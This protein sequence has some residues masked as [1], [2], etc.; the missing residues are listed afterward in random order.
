MFGRRTMD[1][2][3]PDPTPSRESPLHHRFSTPIVVVPY[4][5]CFTSRTPLLLAQADMP[6]L[7]SSPSPLPLCPLCYASLLLRSP[8]LIPYYSTPEFFFKARFAIAKNPA[9]FWDKVKIEKIMR[10]GIILHNMIVED[11]RDGYTRYDL[12]EFQQGE[13]TGTPHVDLTYSTNIPS[14][15]ANMMGVRTRIRDRQMH[16]QLKDDLVEHLWLKF[17]R[18]EDNN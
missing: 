11:E 17:G 6:E 13:D 2:A 5:R 3:L 16:Q 1:L 10:A 9:L 14:N 8:T 4:Q 15:V 12:S 7:F 18:D